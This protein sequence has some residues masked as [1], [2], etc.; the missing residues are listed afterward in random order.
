MVDGPEVL[1][2]S[3]TR[4]PYDPEPDDRVRRREEG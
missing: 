4:T 1:L 2:G 3:V